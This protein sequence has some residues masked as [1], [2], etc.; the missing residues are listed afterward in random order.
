VPHDSINSIS[1]QARVTPHNDAAVS[2]KPLLPTP[3]PPPVRSQGVVGGESVEAS[4]DSGVHAAVPDEEWQSAEWWQ[5]RNEEWTAWQD[6]GSNASVQGWSES[7]SWN[8]APRP[9]AASAHE[10]SVCGTWKRSQ[11]GIRA[12]RWTSS[13]KSR[14][15]A[16]REIGVSEWFCQ[17]CNKDLKTHEKYSRHV[18]ED[19]IPCSE[20]GCTF[21]G[22]EFAMEAHKLKHIRGPDGSAIL[23]SPEEL[24]AWIAVRKANFPSRGNLK[25]KLEKE[26]RRMQCGALLEDDAPKVSMLEK[27]LRSTHGLE[28]R[29]G[30]GY[31]AFGKGKGKGKDKGK[32]GGKKGKKGKKGK[33]KGWTQSWG[34]WTAHRQ[35]ECMEGQAPLALMDTPAWPGESHALVAVPLPS[36]LANVVSLEAPFGPS[37]ALASVAT[38]G[39]RNQPMRG[40]CKF[41]ERGFCFHG[42]NCRYDHGLIQVAGPTGAMTGD[43]TN[44]INSTQQLALTD[45]QAAGVTPW[46]VLP[47][48]LANRA[49]R[50]GEGPSISSSCGPMGS[51]SHSQVH[52]LRP[53]FV[54]PSYQLQERVRRDG[55]LRRLLRPEVH[56]YYSAILQCVRYIVATDF[57]RLERVPGLERPSPSTAVS[58]LASQPNGGL[59]EDDEKEE[60][61]RRILEKAALAET[62]EDLDDAELAELLSVLV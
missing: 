57:L 38:P 47:S 1:P 52:R 8:A 37:S 48:T 30:K 54:Q 18:E 15:S 45:S 28:G 24:K 42:D 17:V 34:S 9:N 12:S 21:S 36:M 33:G 55:L 49:C 10:H 26:E 32:Y 7:S 25:R 13:A 4:S 60:E 51:G 62:T 61:R 19:H 39:Q 20:P 56:S 41:F 58:V 46:W 3:P 2:S 27:V 29:K 5:G 31:G 14:W 53:T 40:L 16:S 43:G 22:P 6:N 50:P 44:F 11:M 59:T 23:E 35:G